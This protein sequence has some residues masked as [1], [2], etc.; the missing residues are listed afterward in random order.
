MS[1]VTVT[2]TLSDTKA[3]LKYLDADG[4]EL[5]AS[6]PVNLDVGK[7]TIK[8]KVTA[9]DGTTKTYVVVVTREG[10]KP[11]PTE[12]PPPLPRSSISTKLTLAIGEGGIDSETLKVYR[13]EGREA[14]SEPFRYVIDLVRVDAANDPL[15][16]SSDDV[17]GKNATLGIEVTEET[18]SSTQTV[19]MMRNVHGVVE[20]FMVEEDPSSA[21]GN[22]YR[23]VLVP[24]LAMLARNRQNRIHATSAPQT[25]EQIIWRKLRSSG[26]DYGSVERVKRVGAGEE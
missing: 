1:Q 13:V 5:A 17:L 7:T 16:L 21:H 23:V 19:P 4:T 22:H 9:E 20:E 15:A 11:E 3:K 26:P 14:I 2:A 8:V 25:L 10:P 24:R 12:P 6:H 18:E